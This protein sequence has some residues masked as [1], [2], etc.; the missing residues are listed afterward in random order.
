MDDI[1]ELIR[2]YSQF[3]D[4]LGEIMNNVFTDLFDQAD[5]G[6]SNS[7]LYIKQPEKDHFKKWIHVKALICTLFCTSVD[8]KW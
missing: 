6:G 3:S 1:N 7:I 5:Y 4:N 8:T 2:Y